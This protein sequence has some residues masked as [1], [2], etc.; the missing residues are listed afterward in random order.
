MR[1]RMTSGIAL[2]LC[3]L[4]I[5]GCGSGAGQAGKTTTQNKPL[6]SAGTVAA[7][8]PGMGA[9]DQFGFD[10]VVEDTAI[11]VLNM[12]DG[13]LMRIDPSA[14]KVVAT[15]AVGRGPGGVALGQ[16]A[17]WTVSPV[18]G[19]VS[20]ID[21]QTN[22]VAATITI[23][24]PLDAPQ[25]IAVS[26]GAVWVAD[27][28]SNA[29]I[30]IDAQRHNVV[31]TIPN[32]LGIVG[33]SY[34]SGSVWACNHHSFNQG[35]V[36]LDPQTHQMIARIN[37]NQVMAQTNPPSNLG[38]C[39]SVRALAQVVWTTTFTNGDPSSTLLERI[40]PTTNTVHTTWRPM[41]MG[42]GSSAPARACIGWIPPRTGWP[43]CSRRRTS[44][45]GWAWAPA[46]CGLFDPMARCCASRPLCESAAAPLRLRACGFSPVPSSGGAGGEVRASGHAPGPGQSGS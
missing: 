22:T 37:P 5:A 34:G 20:R 30:R 26:P 38:A 18:Q 35:L 8:I 7:M 46:R 28:A 11:W 4:M 45:R 23:R 41:S 10:I 31:A 24:Q 13:N 29:L 21:P 6:P 14:N 16:G 32:Q 17:V 1:H 33:V 25:S 3:V 27:H 12:D 40:D 39:F 36:R 44:A 42:C 43:V 19:T 9:S 2:M 15:I